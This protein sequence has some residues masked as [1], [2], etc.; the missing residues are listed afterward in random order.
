[1]Y[2]FKYNFV[3]YFVEVFPVFKRGTRL[4]TN[5]SR[6]RHVTDTSRHV[7]NTS[8][9]GLDNLPIKSSGEIKSLSHTW[10]SSWALNLS[11]RSCRL[12]KCS[13]KNTFYGLIKNL[14]PHTEGLSY[15]KSRCIDI[16]ISQ[17]KYHTISTTF[18]LATINFSASK[19]SN[20]KIILQLNIPS[21]LR[22]L[23]KNIFFVYIF[24]VLK[25]HIYIEIYIVYI[26]ILSPSV[27][28]VDIQKSDEHDRQMNFK[29]ALVWFL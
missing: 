19:Y 21:P 5:T 29:R 10:I 4:V 3:N 23:D 18:L 9:N 15:P 28:L 14:F 24:I 7:T 12:Q 6:T 8:Y 16:M 26:C 17:L 2:R 1:M 25:T 11:D 13:W 20:G 22:D 27:S